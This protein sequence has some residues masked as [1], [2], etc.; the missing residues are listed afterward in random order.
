ML[1]R[2]T[3]DV[4]LLDLNTHED[5]AL[6]EWVRSSSP[7]AA[8]NVVLLTAGPENPETHDLVETHPAT[9]VVTSKDLEGL[10]EAIRKTGESHAPD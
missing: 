3:F 7:N 10:S 9:Q 2:Q 5:A 1:A 8:S 4:V 6:Y